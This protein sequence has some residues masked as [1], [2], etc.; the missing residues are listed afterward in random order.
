MFR[1]KLIWID[2]PAHTNNYNSDVTV[3]HIWQ[4]PCSYANSNLVLETYL[5]YSKTYL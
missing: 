3:K 1:S 4:Q 2:I 5:Q